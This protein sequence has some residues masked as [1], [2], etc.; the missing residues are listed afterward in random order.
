VTKHRIETIVRRWDSGIEAVP[1]HFTLHENHSHDDNL[2]TFSS[3]ISKLE[4][5]RARECF[6]EQSPVKWSTGFWTLIDWLWSWIKFRT[7][8]WAWWDWTFIR[9]NPCFLADHRS[10]VVISFF[11]SKFQL[12]SQ[13]LARQTSFLLETNRHHNASLIFHSAC[14]IWLFYCWIGFVS[15]LGSSYLAESS[16]KLLP[17]RTKWNRPE[18]PYGSLDNPAGI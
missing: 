15:I 6:I 7:T 3:R 16:R 13:M 18:R 8:H 14:L 10:E 9:V 11:R 1:K 5:A 4:P 12:N 2:Q 17:L